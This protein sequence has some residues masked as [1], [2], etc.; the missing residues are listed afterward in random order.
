MSN[1]E[2][3]GVVFMLGEDFHAL[4]ATAEIDLCYLRTDLLKRP[5]GIP[6]GENPVGYSICPPWPPL[7]LDLAVFQG[8]MDI[9][10]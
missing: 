8:A 4:Q 1:I 3:R 2:E 6:C 10:L 7:A 5:R 9:L